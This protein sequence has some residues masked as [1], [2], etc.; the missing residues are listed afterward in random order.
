MPIP[1]GQPS[2]KSKKGGSKGSIALLL[3]SQKMCCVSQGSYP[4]ESIPRERGK[5]GSKHAKK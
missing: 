4:R 3:E 5:F 1:N 2:K